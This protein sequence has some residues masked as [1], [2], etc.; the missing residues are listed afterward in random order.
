MIRRTL[1]DSTRRETAKGNRKRTAHTGQKRRLLMENLEGRRLL[2]SDTAFTPVPVDP[3]LFAAQT[4][5]NVGTVTAVQIGENEAA[6]ARGVNDTINTATHLPL[7]TLPSQQDTIDV[8]GSIGIQLNAQ[9]QILSDLDYYAMDLRAGDILDISLNGVAGNIS[10]L[11]GPGTQAPGRFWF[12]TDSNQ[13]I[14]DPATGQSIYAKGSPLQTRGSAVAAQV[15]PETGRYYIGLAPSLGVSNYTMGLRVYRPVIEQA[16]R[17]AQ[18]IL[19]LDFDGGIYPTSEIS[20]STLPLGV[21]RFDRLEDN[22]GVLGF[23][24]PTAVDAQVLQENILDE[25]RD[26]FDTIAVNGSNGDYDETGIGGQYGITIVSSLECPE[27][28]DRSACAVGNT[29]LNNNPLVTRVLI[30]GLVSSTGIDGA[31][32]IAESVDIGNFRPGEITIVQLDDISATTTAIARSPAVSEMDV[33]SK[34]L[35]GVVSH[36]AG[37][38]FGERHT[39]NTNNTDNIMDAGG[40]LQGLIDSLIAPGPDGILGTADDLSP[41]FAP[42]DQFTPAEGFFGT[43]RTATSLSFELSTGTAT[44]SITG[45]VFNDLNRDGAFAGDAGLPGVFVYADLDGDRVRDPIEPFDVSAPDGAY[46]LDVAP[47]LSYTVVA[48]TPAQYVASNSTVRSNVSAGVTNLNFGF[49]KVIADVTGTKF[50]DLNG[51]GL[52]DTNESGMGG[53]YIY[54]DLDGDD[55]PDLGEPSAITAADGSYSINFPGPGTYTIREVVEPGFEQTFP[56]SGEHIVT[57]N[58]VGLTDNYNFGNLPSRDYGDAPDSYGTSIAAGGPSHGTSL[59]VGLG[60]EVDREID[61]FPSANALGDDNNNI[62]DEDGIQLLSPLGPGGTATV[63]VTARN[64]TGQPAY[65][66]GWVDF[67][68]NGTFDASERVFNNVVVADG[69]SN[70]EINVPGNAV[71]GSTYARF[72]YSP[73]AGLGVGGDADL[74]EVEDYQFDILQQADI[75]N[76]DEFTVS[77]NS[78]SNQLDVLAND[79]Q[80]NLT[81]L[82]I[83][84]LNVVGTSGV[85]SVAGDGKSIFYTPRNGFTGLDTFQYTVQDQLGNQ[86]T[87]DV[88][89]TVSFQSNVPIAVDDIFDIPQGSSNRPLNVLANDVPSIAGGIRIISVTAGDQGGNVALEGGGQTIRYTPVAGFTGTEQF[90]YSIQDSNGQVST[91]QVTVNSQPGA[92]NDDL[93]DFTIGIFDVVNNQ[94]ISSVQVGQEFYVRVFV[95]ELNNPNFSPEGV[96]SAFLDLLYSDGLVSTQDTIGGDAFGFDITFGPN[97]QGSGFQL[98]DATTPGLIDDVGAVQPIGGG[99]LIRHSDPAELFTITMTAVSPGVAVFKADPADAVQAETIL[100]GEDDAL[101]VAQQRLGT[102]ELTIFPTTDNFA[103]AIDDAFSAGTDSNGILINSANGPN[104]L[105]VLD[106]DLFG[107]TGTLLEFGIGIDP[108]LGNVTID[109]NGTPSDLTDDTINYFANTNASGFDSFTY[110]IV[111]G[112]G[113]RSVGEV[114]M[115]IGQADDDD[116]VDISFALVDQFNNPITSVA[117]GETFGV[118]VFVEDLR[119]VVEGNT[120]VFA[121]YLDML[122]DAGVLAPGSVP[123]GG[124][125]DFDVD[126]D[127]DFDSNAGVG[128]A[129]RAGIIDEFG[130]LLRDTVVDSGAI[131]EPNL[132]ATVYFTAGPVASTTVTQVVGS[133][134]DSSPFQDTLLFDR[135]QPVPVSQI[136]YDVLNVTVTPVSTLQNQ[137]MPEDVNNDGLVTPSDALTVIN[138]LGRV[139][140]GEQSAPTAFTDVNGD[141]LT[142]P[143]DALMVINHLARLAAS[144]P[145]EGESIGSSDDAS[146]SNDAAI[147]GLIGSTSIDSDDEE[148]DL[149]ALLAA[150]QNTLA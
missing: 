102:A 75:A 132:M 91:A 120:F 85:A 116:L 99:D 46:R 142:S 32:G 53:V 83:V 27:F 111:S 138:A 26:H 127:N 144:S 18:Q 74:G 51:N 13:A 16:P 62:D 109:D 48:E 97:F 143:M 7:G 105:D 112:D 106:N 67:N 113:V 42:E 40:N 87:A 69:V 38:T 146:S 88:S 139:G 65:L 110:Y 104:T 47:G 92:R 98:G 119:T 37:H 95:E 73:T 129:A 101:T 147:G 5:R 35:A 39:T 118:Q 149:L 45:R 103:S 148:D 64:T 6:G 66:Q 89:V 9:N 14:L 76:D 121:G 24:N 11:Y 31:Y 36:E 96:A 4:P 17:G 79:F 50:A 126:F 3:A 134:A 41:V 2:A 55:R 12:G 145:A 72:R 94:P 150:D 82:T 114:T 70:L 123:A 93:V 59:A 34:F 28:G 131:N 108:T 22:L 33:I 1:S 19:Y 29:D 61:G 49:T 81:Q 86:Y 141:F 117:S 25:V 140:E 137:A 80:S 56:V 115:A 60:A 84:N 54:L 10:V 23:T 15:V 44:S 124:R 136:R 71:V 122:Y 52:F 77:R 90:S 78:L 100:V 135:D 57:Y 21:V 68:A 8:T 107:P 125:Y 30:G 128:T 63:Q 130:S 43:T 133:P 20:G 58:G